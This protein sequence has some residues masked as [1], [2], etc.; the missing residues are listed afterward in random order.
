MISVNALA[1]KQEKQNR[2]KHM[3]ACVGLVRDYLAR[4]EKINESPEMSRSHMLG[5]LFGGG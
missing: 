5:P 1:I 3:C 2:S 4:P